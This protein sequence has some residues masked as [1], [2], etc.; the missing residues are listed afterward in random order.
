VL[1]AVKESK[2]R[3]RAKFI[4]DLLTG[5]E[6]SEIKNY[7]GDK[8]KATAAAPRRTASTGWP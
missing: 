5:T 3:H 4:C 6:T 7:K 1:A 2:E 8:L